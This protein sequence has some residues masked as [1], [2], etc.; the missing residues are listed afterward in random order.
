M[1]VVNDALRDELEALRSIYPDDGE[2]LSITNV[3]ANN[4]TS[5]ILTIPNIPYSFSILFPPAYPD[6]ALVVQGTHHV[7]PDVRHGEGDVAT[8]ILRDVLG[9]TFIPGQVCIFDLIE[10]ASP[11]LSQSQPQSHTVHDI[12]SDDHTESATSRS[13]TPTFTSID[14]S[15]SSVTSDFF[16]AAIDT[17]PSPD[18][19]LSNPLTV[20]KSTFIA[21]ALSITSLN[22]ATSAISHLLSTNRR[23]AAA[24]HNITAWRI[25]Q[26]TTTTTT[27][28]HGPSTATDTSHPTITIQDC[29]DDGETAAGGRLLHLMHLMDVWNVVVV[30]TRWYGGVKLGPD[31]FR[32]INVVAREVLVAGGFAKEDTGSN[33]SNKSGAAKNTKKNNKK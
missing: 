33:S 11:L 23:V 30:V 18:W 22:E 19:V 21:R 13:A 25:R 32:L 26:N 3:D 6:E 12:A 10:E 27:A 2:V 5:A 1:S 17:T 20:N 16:P 9:N 24:T 8:S 28:H 31:R 4:V 7:G 29:D 14:P 15:S